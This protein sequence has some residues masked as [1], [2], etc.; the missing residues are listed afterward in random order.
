M[1]NELLEMAKPTMSKLANDGITDAKSKM[2]LDTAKDAVKIAYYLYKIDMMKKQM[3]GMKENRMEYAEDPM[4]YAGNPI[5]P[6]STNPK[7]VY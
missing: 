2:E 3:T 6:S 5:D 4:G 7:K 1:A